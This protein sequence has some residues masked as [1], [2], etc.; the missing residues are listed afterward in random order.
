[1]EKE[2]NIKSFDSISSVQKTSS[3][4]SKDSDSKFYCNY[5]L[6]SVKDNCVLYGL[7]LHEL[8][9]CFFFA[10]QWYDEAKNTFYVKHG[11]EF[12]T[13]ILLFCEYKR[14]ELKFH[15]IEINENT[16]SRTISGMY[17]Y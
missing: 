15:L 11:D 1:M 16:T 10:V 12:G 5:K 7:I 8:H 6:H 4:E 17:I 3:P 14:E 13:K 9:I 2:E